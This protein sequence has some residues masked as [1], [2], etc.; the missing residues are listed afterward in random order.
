LCFKIGLILAF[1]PIKLLMI[2]LINN[3]LSVNILLFI[4]RILFDQKLLHYDL[5][6]LMLSVIKK[7]RF[8]K[9]C[10]FKIEKGLK[11]NNIEC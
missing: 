1:Y 4:D 5:K 10:V 3:D 6:F 2:Q 11:T 9:G 7:E 8:K